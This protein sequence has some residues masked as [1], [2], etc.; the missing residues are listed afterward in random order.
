[1]DIAQTYSKPYKLF[2]Q[3]ALSYMFDRVL[4]TALYWNCFSDYHSQID[5]RKS[6]KIAASS[7]ETFQNGQAIFNKFWESL[8]FSYPGNTKAF[9]Y[10]YKCKFPAKWLLNYISQYWEEGL[11]S[12]FKRVLNTCPDLSYIS[13]PAGIYLL[14]I[15]NRNTRTRSEISSKLAIRIRMMPGSLLLTLNI[16]HTFFQCFYCLLWTSKCLL[17]RT[18][19]VYK[20]GN[21]ILLQLPTDV[22]KCWWNSSS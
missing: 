21:N 20:C 1:M 19:S 8:W 3:N 7:L 11:R 12:I 5:I 15:S 6:D 2:S 14:K 10:I 13:F 22:Q 16:F 4:K 9:W 18:V 17:G